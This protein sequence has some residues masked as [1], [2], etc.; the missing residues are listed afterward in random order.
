MPRDKVI[1]LQWQAEQHMGNG[2][3]KYKAKGILGNNKVHLVTCDM[4]G[5]QSTE[6]SDPLLQLPSLIKLHTSPSSPLH[7]PQE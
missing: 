3:G 1:S 6:P 5:V 2:K 4:N 7:S